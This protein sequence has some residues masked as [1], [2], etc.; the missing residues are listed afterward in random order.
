MPG[1]DAMPS[2]SSDE[3]PNIWLGAF[4]AGTGDSSDD[5]WIVSRGD[6][7]WSRF[8]APRARSARNG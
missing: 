1:D 5:Y 7:A 2:D 4:N 8:G 6:W 3:T